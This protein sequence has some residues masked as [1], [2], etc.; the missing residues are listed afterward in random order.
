MYPDSSDVI[1][2]AR[3]AEDMRHAERPRPSRESTRRGLQAP[4]YLPALIAAFAERP[5]A[6]Y[7]HLPAPEPDV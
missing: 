6:T 5:L 4:V 2:R 1:V 7:L 3:I